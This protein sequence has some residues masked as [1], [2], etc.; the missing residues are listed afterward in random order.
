[1]RQRIILWSVTALIVAAGILIASDS[2]EQ[3][4]LTLP[5]RLERAGFAP[6]KVTLVTTRL[7][8]GYQGT[9]PNRTDRHDLGNLRQAGFGLASARR[10]VK[11]L[12]RT[13]SVVP[14]NPVPVPT[15][16]PVPTSGQTVGLVANADHQ[17]VID[18]AARL[19]TVLIRQEFDLDTPVAEVAADVAYAKARGIETITQVGI[20]PGIPSPARSVQACAWP[21]KYLEFGNET[22]FSYQGTQNEG[23]AYGRAAQAVAQCAGGRL[24]VQADDGNTGSGWTGAVLRGGPQLGSLV[25]GW[26]IHPYGPRSRWFPRMERA[27]NELGVAGVRDPNMFVTEWG[28]S[29]DDGRGLEDN[30]GFATNLSYTAAGEL[31]RSN[32][33]DM[34]V[35]FPQIKAFTYYQV[36]DQQGSGSG[37]REHYFGAT[38]NDGSDKPGLT[39]DVRFLLAR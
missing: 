27:I 29:S 9:I 21:G 26:T 1:M 14:P 24:L 32:V 31:I 39:D 8:Q 35:Q 7:K 28:I 23:E 20:R 12:R 36:T 17:R 34:L 18:V 33:T 15:P 22:G 16:T 6:A 11:T 19:G 2:R 38:K 13:P 4:R 10:I 3:A 30:Y 25:A 37:Q 5:Q